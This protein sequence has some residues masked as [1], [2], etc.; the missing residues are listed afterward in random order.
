VFPSRLEGF[1]LA[2]AEAM[3]CGK[4]VVASRAGALP[5]VVADSETGI[6]CDPDDPADFAR[7][8]LRLLEDPSLAE[9]MGKAGLARAKRLFQWDET[10]RRTLAIY[11]EAVREWG[12]G[13]RR[14]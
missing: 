6:L 3:A 10:A 9:K 2:A 4:S 7:A 5:E 14:A 13:R 1:G 11:E 8:I 12:K